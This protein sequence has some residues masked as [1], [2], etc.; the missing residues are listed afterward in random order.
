MDK[1]KNGDDFYS[2]FL[3]YVTDLLKNTYFDAINGNMNSVESNSPWSPICT[4]STVVIDTNQ[5]ILTGSE[6]EKDWK[7]YL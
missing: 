3:H 6:N 2:S 7:T 4:V 1:T 5:H